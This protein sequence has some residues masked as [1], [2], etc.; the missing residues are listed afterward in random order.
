[1]QIYSPTKFIRREKPRST[2]LSQWSERCDISNSY[3]ISASKSPTQVQDE[4][5]YV[6][7]NTNKYLDKVIIYNASTYK[8]VTTA[9]RKNTILPVT[10]DQAQFA[11]N[12]IIYFGHSR[13]FTSLR[14]RLSP[15]HT[16]SLNL[17]WEYW[18]SFN[19]KWSTITTVT[20]NTAGFNI[21][22]QNMTWTSTL[23]GDFYN[24][25]DWDS[26]E[27]DKA[28]NVTGVDLV[29]RWWMRIKIISSPANNFKITQAT[30]DSETTTSL[31][32][33][34][35]G[36][37]KILL[38]GNRNVIIYP[39]TAMIRGRIF[40]LEETSK[41]FIPK[42]EGYFIRYTSVCIDAAYNTISLVNGVAACSPKK[43]I[44]NTSQY[45]LCDISVYT[46]S[47]D[48][49]QSNILDTRLIASHLQ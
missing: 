13:P 27:F 28:V 41:F 19:L 16:G 24:V 8:D 11:L 42:Q 36:T 33:I 7:Y 35:D 21:D 25:K 2:K 30:F 40:E 4:L 23:F 32:V 39:G 6:L 3:L 1:M 46:G 9:V 49:L 18:D 45:K 26:I 17:E 20:D 34:A 14:F 47:S 22:N 12:D 44:I 15:V 37:N 38:E 43:P 10:P 29:K 48:I 31:K 5:D